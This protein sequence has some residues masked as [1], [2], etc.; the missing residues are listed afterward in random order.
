MAA[1]RGSIGNL[2]GLRIIPREPECIGGV[3]S[4]WFSAVFA[5]AVALAL[6][7]PAGAANGAASAAEPVDGAASARPTEAL[8][9]SRETSAYEAWK[10]KDAKF[11]PSFLDERFVGWGSS[12]RLDKAS[13]AKEY[14]GADCTIA[15]IAISGAQMTPLGRDAALITHKTIVDGTCGGEKIPHDRWAASVYVRDGDQW[16]A[17]FHAE[18]AI[19]DPKAPM[20]PAG[21]AVAGEQDQVNAADLDAATD[22][23]LAR[24]QAAWDGWKDRD[25]KR[26]DDLLAANVQFINIFGIHLATKAEA[27]NNWSG[28]G[29]DVKRVALTG[30]QAAMLSPKVGVLT[31]HAR[32]EGTCFGQKVG[33]I[34]GSSVYVRRGDIWKWTFGINLPARVEG[35]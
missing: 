24:E 13:A 5:G 1:Q 2:Q 8:L 21:K 6:I 20:K 31:F 19:V 32:A 26:M 29:C 10:S 18:A 30:A 15:R 34:W 28:K 16:K 27:L 12:G 7:G 33:P 9:L 4:A 35:G 17:A 23:L 3:M 14:T 22:A 25:T 11:W